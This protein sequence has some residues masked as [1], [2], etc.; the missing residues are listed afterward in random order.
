MSKPPALTFAYQQGADADG[1][2]IVTAN[3]K[4]VKTVAGAPL[5]LPEGDLAAAIAT[6]M[7]GRFGGLAKCPLGTAFGLGRDARHPGA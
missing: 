5:V 6:E 4:P 2:W 1:G 3:G 7:Q